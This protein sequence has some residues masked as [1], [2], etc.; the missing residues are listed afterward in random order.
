MVMWRY[1]QLATDRTLVK[2]LL[3]NQNYERNYVHTILTAC[4]A[5]ADP[6]PKDQKTSLKKKKNDLVALFLKGL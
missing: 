4:K 5:F 2:C 3:P 6:F 1:L